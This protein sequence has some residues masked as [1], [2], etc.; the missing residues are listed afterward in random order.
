MTFRDGTMLHR[1]VRRLTSGYSTLW[2]NASGN[3][4]TFL[5]RSSRQEQREQEKH[6][7]ALRRYET[8][9]LKSSR[10]VGRVEARKRIMAFVAQGIPGRAGV[11][12][13]R[14]LDDC[15]RAGEKFVAQARSF[16]PKMTDADVQ[17]ALRNLWVFN[18]IQFYL[19]KPVSVTPSSFAY[20]VLYPYTDNWLDGTG[21]AG[22]GKQALLRW[23]SSQLSGRPVPTDDPRK[24]GIA[25]L[26]GMIRKEHPRSRCPDV[27]ES[28]LAIHRAQKKALFLRGAASGG[29]E[30]SLIPLTIEKGG[31]SVLVD[32]YLAGHLN[33][34]QAEAIFG[35]GVLLQLV[36]DLQDLQ[37]DVDGGQSSPFSRAIRHGT[38]EGLTNRLFNLTRIV[39]N[40]LK[41][42]DSPQNDHVAA[43]VERSCTV[44]IE[45]AIARHSHL[46]RQGYLSFLNRFAPVR[47]AYLRGIGSH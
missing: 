46:Y 31:T 34:V 42:H 33:N 26:L 11:L 47:F 13:R 10:S 24:A 7:D 15:G 32:G 39:A 9:F 14:F 35:Y 28:L 44:L 25:A 8:V 37:E 16:D 3:P 41:C 17:Q 27:H 40:Q 19:G 29:S 1:R 2:F 6:V 45:E 23:L 22:R 12:V 5:R 30:H 4:P 21:E 18:S 43:L 38:L 20:S 36:D